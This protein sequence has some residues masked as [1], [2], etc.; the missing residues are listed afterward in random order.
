M[1][2]HSALISHP[3]MSVDEYIG[4]HTKYPCLVCL[5]IY[6]YIVN[7]VSILVVLDPN[8]C[9][10]FNLYSWKMRRAIIISFQNTHIKFIWRMSIIFYLSSCDVCRITDVKMVQYLKEDSIP[11]QLYSHLIMALIVR[12]GHRGVASAWIGHVHP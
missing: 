7:Y 3:T 10:K 1:H 12:D 8:L 6:I 4:V 11:L 5:Y 2:L 9:I